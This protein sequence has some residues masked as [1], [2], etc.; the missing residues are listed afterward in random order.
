M[1][2]FSG[3]KLVK[4]KELDSKEQAEQYTDK[5]NNQHNKLN[6]PEWYIYATMER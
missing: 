2:R 3:R 1:D 5:I 4:I 6:V